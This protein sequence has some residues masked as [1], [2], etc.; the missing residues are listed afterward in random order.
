[1]DLVMRNIILCGFMGCGKSTI[2]KKLAA[3][4][5][6]PFTDMDEVIE[7]QAG[8]TV[9]EIFERFGEA[10]FRRRER[11]VSK[12]LAA[13]QNLIVA[14]GGGTLTYPENV[15]TLSVTGDIVLLEVPLEVILRRLDRDNSR[16]LL[17]C[18]DKEI[19][20][21]ELYDLRLPYYRAASKKTINA[22]GGSEQVAKEICRVFG[23]DL[24]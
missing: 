7:Q 1:M 17:A 15:D 22:E 19:K 13:K 14:A 10:D 12:L 21:K 6:R 20:A 4:T 18:P 23:I 2:G 24:P 5:G 9:S 11:D 16:P 8:M 3:M